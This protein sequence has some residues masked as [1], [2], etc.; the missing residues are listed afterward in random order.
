M[1]FPHPSNPLEIR[2]PKQMPGLL[3]FEHSVRLQPRRLA[4][5]GVW[6]GWCVEQRQSF[7]AWSCQFTQSLFHTLPPCSLKII[8]VPWL[9]FRDAGYFSP[10]GN[11]G[12]NVIC[13]NSYRTLSP[14]TL[15]PVP[16]PREGPPAF[17]NSQNHN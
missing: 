14:Q 11:D 1:S 4:W 3:S 16:L 9:L 5:E 8:S 6:K 7:R 15:R 12:R 13:V 17:G 2:P 10:V